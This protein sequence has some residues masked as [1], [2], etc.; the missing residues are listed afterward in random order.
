MLT[1]IPR[2]DLALGQPA[3]IPAT[4]LAASVARRQV[5][6]PAV[7]EDVW[8]EQVAERYDES[9]VAMAT[10]EVLDPALPSSRSWLMV[11]AL[12]NSLSGQG[13]WPYR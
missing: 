7:Q 11:A 8:T 2:Y 10:T 13:A 5:A 3:P 4:A 9:S 12:L 1:H 6:T